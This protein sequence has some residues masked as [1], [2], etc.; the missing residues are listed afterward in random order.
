MAANLSPDARIPVAPHHCV[1]EPLLE[2]LLGL[3]VVCVIGVR[4]GR[5]G[6]RVAVGVDG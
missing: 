4:H 5:L 3:V 6:R 1:I 2:W